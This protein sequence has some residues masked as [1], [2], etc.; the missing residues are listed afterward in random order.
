MTK[1]EKTIE[2]LFRREQEFEAATIDA[3]EK[4]HRYKVDKAVAYLGANGSIEARKAI[5]EEIC[6][7]AY[8]DHLKADARAVIAKEKL[9]DVRAVISARQTI[10]SNQYKSNVII[11][12]NQI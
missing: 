3:V 2:E 6:S 1:L 11:S 12:K 9:N 5:A 7:D 8:L 10:E 4:E